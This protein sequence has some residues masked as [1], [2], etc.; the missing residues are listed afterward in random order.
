MKYL[1]FKLLLSTIFCFVVLLG[2]RNEYELYFKN[3]S[4]EVESFHLKRFD[5][6]INYIACLKGNIISFMRDGK[7]II[8]PGFIKPLDKG[9]FIFSKE[10][11]SLVITNLNEN[12]FQDSFQYIHD[13]NKPNYLKLE[14]KKI[15][16]ICNR[17]G[18]ESNGRI[19]PP[20]YNKLFDKESWDTSPCYEFREIFQLKE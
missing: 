12:Y 20:I 16:I 14:S 18:I 4:W 17:I 8:T 9:N 5:Q 10:D 3:Q 7:S 13:F 11:K 1:K 2:C 19:G 15:I 6:E